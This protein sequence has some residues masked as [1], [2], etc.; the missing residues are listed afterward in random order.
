MSLKTKTLHGF[1]WSL[2]QQFGVQ[3]TMIL[4]TIFLARILEPADFGLIGMLAVFMALGNSLIDAGMTSS[5]IRTKD[6]DQRDFSTVFFINLAVGVLVYLAMVFSAGLISEFFN[7]PALKAIIKVYCLT[8]L[9]YPFSAVQRTRLVKNMDFKTE[10]KITIPSTIVGGLLG[11]VL[12]FQGFGVWALVGMNLAQN[13]L[14]SVQFW[15]YSNWRP[16]WVIDWERFKYHFGYG[17]K[18]TLAGVINSV[19]SNIYHL[20]IGKFFPVTQLG[21]YTKADSLKQIPVKNI[22]NTLS[23]VTFPMFSEI[24]DDDEKLKVAY[25]RIMQQVLFWL[26]PVMA[27]SAV[28]A[29]PL[30]RIVLTEKWIPA[31]PYFQILCFIGLM[32]PI[33]SYNLNILKVKGR[34]DLFLKLE[35]IKKSLTVVGIIIALPYG[36][37]ALLWTQVILNLVAF[38]INSFYSG[39]FIGY[40]V[41]SQLR[42][43]LPIF[44]IGGVAAIGGWFVKGSI[45]NFPAVDW[46]QLIGGG[47]IGIMIYFLISWGAKS[48][49]F[50]DFRKIILKK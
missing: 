41:W 1:F 19:F 48:E 17:A 26:T 23:K 9:I 21:Y 44:L 47:L 2:T 33:H 11:L 36:I 40:N 18:L 46:I 29:E 5:L 28:L 16:S 7:Q 34:S 6:A 24:Q 49:P 4:V 35:I 8:F 3:L 13:L 12:A 20:V 30:F 38:G 43:I 14:L 50:V 37:F 31:V 25:K 22:S 27:L 45:G 10:L 32:F 42:D 15:V 39:R